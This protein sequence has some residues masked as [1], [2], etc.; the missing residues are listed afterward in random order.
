[1]VESAPYFFDSSGLGAIVGLLLSAKKAGCQLKL[2]NLTPRV[3]PPV[4]GEGI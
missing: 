3:D 1:V 2:I 4:P